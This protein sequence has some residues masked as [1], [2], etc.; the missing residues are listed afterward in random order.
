MNKKKKELYAPKDIYRITGLDRK[1]LFNFKDIIP[2]TDHSNDFV[3][4]NE[5]N[6]FGEGYKLYDE[7]ALKQFVIIS[8]LKELGV[9]NAEI[10]K[11][12]IDNS[13]GKVDVLFKIIEDAEA[14]I[15]RLNDII[16]VAEECAATGLNIGRD[17]LRSCGGMGELADYIRKYR[18]TDEYQQVKK[19][20]ESGFD[21]DMDKKWREFSYPLKKYWIKK[22]QQ[23]K[24]ML[25]LS[26]LKKYMTTYFQVWELKKESLLIMV[27]GWRFMV[28]RI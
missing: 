19:L 3:R 17:S 28:M 5:G 4:K 16:L 26:H 24:H 15:K 23:E 1:T 10:K 20:M 11:M 12:F 8:M 6:D 22:C 14:E 7:A 25:I 2:A 18:Q 21:D 9:Q 27:L 13:V